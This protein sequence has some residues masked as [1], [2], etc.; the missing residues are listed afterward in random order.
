[1]DTRR[2]ANEDADNRL[3]KKL[4]LDKRFGFHSLRHT[5]AP[6]LVKEG[7]SIYEVQKLP[8]HSSV[9]VTQVYSHLAASELQGTV[10]KLSLN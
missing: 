8:G 3:V 5:F 6:W 2:H 1:M 9:A 4:G 10:N 7:V